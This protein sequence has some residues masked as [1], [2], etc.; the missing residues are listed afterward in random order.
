MFTTDGPSLNDVPAHER[1]EIKFQQ[2]LLAPAGGAQGINGFL[3]NFQFS[4]APAHGGIPVV[5]P[6]GSEA[7]ES[8]LNAAMA[9][10]LAP[11]RLFEPTA[12]PTGLHNAV[13]SEVYEGAL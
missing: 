7:Q 13:Y 2:P 5:L 4:G 1:R 12:L 6:A 11:G 10:V 9:M 8:T 3:A